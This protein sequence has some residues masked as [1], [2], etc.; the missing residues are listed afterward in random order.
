MVRQKEEG[1]LYLEVNAKLTNEKKHD[2]RTK[3]A[4]LTQMWKLAIFF[5]LHCELCIDFSHLIGYLLC[6]NGSFNS[7]S[8]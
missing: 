6:Y 1:I 2:F 4:D 7:D 5:S 8:S 3:E